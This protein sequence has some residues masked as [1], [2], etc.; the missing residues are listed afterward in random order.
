MH[1]PFY[2]LGLEKTGIST[3]RI[4]DLA[5]MSQKLEPFG[6]QAV[7]V[8]GFI[9]PAAFME[10]QS[11][12]L[13]PIACDMR[14]I[15]HLTYTP[16]PDIVHEAAGHAPI[17]IDPEFSIYLKNMR[18]SPANRFSIFEIWKFTKPSANFRI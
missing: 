10:M 12:G 9:P 7:P 8:S 1:I 6:W 4:P 18:K 17:L 5:E 13:L 14:S 15:E 2:A 3:E 11:L 16:A